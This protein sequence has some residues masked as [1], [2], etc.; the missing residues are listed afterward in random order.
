MI[1]SLRIH[2]PKAT[3]DGVLVQGM[4]KRGREVIIGMKRDPQF[5]PLIMFGLGGIYVE[6]LR[7]V[8]FRLAPVREL[9]TYRMIEGIRSHRLLE[10]VRG[11]SPADVDAIAECIMRLS[12]LCIE[13]DVI[14]ELDINPL[15]VYPKGEGAFVADAR[16]ALRDIA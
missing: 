5:G 15:I 8:T 4:A 3:V 7:D 1:D 16:I 11:E 2:Q 6:T 13:Q 12:Q 9:G 14:D 10:G